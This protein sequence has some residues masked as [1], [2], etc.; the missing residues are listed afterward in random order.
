T[1]PCP[2][3]SRIV[4]AP[5]AGAPAPPGPAPGHSTLRPPLAAEET[6]ASLPQLA[7][8]PDYP[9]L[10]PADGPDALGR[11]GPYRVLTV[12]GSGAMGV[13]FEAD[14]PHLKRRV[15][16]KVMKPSLA[17]SPEFHRRF[18]REAQLA[19]AIDHEHLVTIYQV[20]EDHGVPFLAM[21]LLQGETLE[22]R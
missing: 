3:C 19:A 20:G 18:R 4:Q 22:D 13:I 17:A 5:P 1:G 2:R 12:L 7:P 15:A 16:L 9:F 21:Q 10:G 6:A 8:H 11:L 14:D